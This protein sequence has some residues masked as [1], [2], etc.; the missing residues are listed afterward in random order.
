MLSK[1]LEMNVDELGNLGLTAGEE[2]AVVAYL[3]TLSDGYR[4]RQH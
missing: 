4:T 3:K 1:P 2:R